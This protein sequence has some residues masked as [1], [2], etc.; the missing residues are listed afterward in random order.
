MTAPGDERPG[1][2]QLPKL[3]ELVEA[4]AAAVGADPAGLGPEA[5][6]T[7]VCADS[8]DLYCLYV[9]LDEWVPGFRLP[10]QLEL[11]A[12]TLADVHHYLV[13][14][15]EQR[16]ARQQARQPA[17]GQTRSRGR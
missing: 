13:V 5:R 8:L 9:T 17:R 10:R 11:D 12:A 1:P 15:A 14:R 2:P 3:H 4:V 6:V 7:E 16:Q